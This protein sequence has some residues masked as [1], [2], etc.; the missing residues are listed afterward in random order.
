ME[1]VVRC[2]LCRK[3]FDE[4]ESTTHLFDVLDVWPL[5][6]VESS[7]KRHGYY[8]RTRRQ[9]H[10][11]NSRARAC[12]ACVKAKAKCDDNSLAC[13]RCAAKGLI[14]KPS[15]PT[16]IRK[17]RP[18]S[19]T[20]SG[21]TPY[22]PGLAA[23]SFQVNGNNGRSTE[24]ENLGLVPSHCAQQEVPWEFSSWVN[25]GLAAEDMLSLQTPQSEWMTM[26]A[27]VQSPIVN[28]Q[29]TIIIQ[30][31]SGRQVRSFEQ[32]P[33]NRAPRATTT[34]MARI[35]TSYPRMMQS[36]ESL[37]PFI[38]PFS[39]VDRFEPEGKPFES[40]TTCLA[41]M[42]MAAIHGPGKNRLIW[43]NIRLECERIRDEVILPL[44]KYGDY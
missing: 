25:D 22:I 35:L 33:P 42:Q 9:S 23:T 44:P 2:N 30:P 19:L 16:T 10:K 29:P 27:S 5:M 28:V 18:K 15:K 26:D 12:E 41:L 21:I 4:S 17:T 13:A 24:I 34:M 43:K 6:D 11:I 32:R 37:P 20:K 36:Q 39:L 3:P 31:A 1:D 14:C 38:H 7:L 40:V 8:C